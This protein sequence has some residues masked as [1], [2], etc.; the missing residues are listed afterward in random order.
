MPWLPAS[1]TPTLPPASATTLRL[2]P[3]SRSA[4]LPRTLPLGCVPAVALPMPRASVAV[5]VSATAV[6]ASLA[7]WIEKLIVASVLFTPSEA[8]TVKLCVALPVRPCTAALFGVK[9]QAPV[10][11]WMLSVP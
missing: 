6:I 1:A 11:D 10:P 8:R 9:V 7:P 4:S 5:A 3:L 2:S